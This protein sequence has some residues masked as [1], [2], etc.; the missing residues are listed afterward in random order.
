MA[1]NVFWPDVHPKRRGRIHVFFGALDDHPCMH[2]RPNFHDLGMSVWACCGKFPDSL[3]ATDG[4]TRPKEAWEC[5][6]RSVAHL[7]A[8]FGDVEILEVRLEGFWPSMSPL[9]GY[10]FPSYVSTIRLKYGD[11]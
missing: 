11:E 9:L 10:L 6:E 4:F 3:V 2:Y 8:V 1:R 7:G 5:S